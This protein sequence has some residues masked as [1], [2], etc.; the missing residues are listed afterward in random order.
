MYGLYSSYK[1]YIQ[2][3]YMDP[4]EQ[5]INWLT[6]NDDMSK[7]LNIHTLYIKRSFCY[8]HAVFN[9]GMPLIFQNGAWGHIVSPYAY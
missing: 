1:W 6:V 8:T 7:C 3:D 5:Q 2:L 9:E 4:A